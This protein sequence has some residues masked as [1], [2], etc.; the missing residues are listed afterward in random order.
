MSEKDFFQGIKNREHR[1]LEKSIEEARGKVLSDHFPSLQNKSIDELR[2][3]EKLLNQLQGL[4]SLATDKFYQHLPSPLEEVR[5]RSVW[6]VYLSGLRYLFR[7][8]PQGFFRQTN[9]AVGELQDP[10]EKTDAYCDK[11]LEG[12]SAIAELVQEIKKYCEHYKT[13]QE[14]IQHYG[15]WPKDIVRLYASLKTWTRDDEFEIFENR[16]HAAQKQIFEVIIEGPIQLYLLVGEE[17]WFFVLK[18]LTVERFQDFFSDKNKKDLQDLRE[19]HR[20]VYETVE[21]STTY[22]TFKQFFQE[23]LRIYVED[24][25]KDAK[26]LRNQY[27]TDDLRRKFIRRFET[28]EIFRR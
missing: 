26:Q 16:V 18:T 4:L 6:E 11:C 7:R 9:L 20:A 23:S 10:L 22:E 21:I 3:Y 27:P 2:D 8:Y 24:S 28:G 12:F 19:L 13:G 5:E 17:N 15:Q 1:N 14:I 25:L